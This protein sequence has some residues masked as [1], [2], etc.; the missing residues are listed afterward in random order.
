MN[1]QKYKD[2]AL[3]ETVDCNS[4]QSM[5][6]QSITKRYSAIFKLE[7]TYLRQTKTN[8]QINSNKLKLTQKQPTSNKPQQNQRQITSNKLKQT[9]RQI[10]SNKLKQFQTNSNKQTNKLKPAQK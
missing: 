2:A 1:L 9:Q 7:A 6:K 5:L 4:W 3:Y 8:S 10:T